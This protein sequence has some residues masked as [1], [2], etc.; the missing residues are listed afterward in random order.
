MLALGLAALLVL[1]ALAE[2]HVYARTAAVPVRVRVA[3]SPA[4]LPHGGA[5]ELTLRVERAG[6]LPVPWLTA[7]ITLPPDLECAAAQGRS[8]IAHLALP[9]RGALVRHYPVR[10]RHRGLYRVEGVRV[11][12][13][14][15]LGL[16]VRHV[17]LAARAEMLVHPRLVAADMVASTRT[18]LGEVEHTALLEDP[19]AY[20]GV[21]PYLPGDPLRRVHWPQ[22]ARTG[23]LMAREYATAAAAQVHLALNLATRVPH[24]AGTD[25]A[26]V[27]QVIEAAASLAAACCRAAVPVGL[28]VNGVAF[29]ATPITRLPPG[30]SPR[31]LTRLLDVLARLAPQPSA[32]AAALLDALWSVPRDAN[33]VLVTGP[34]P[35]AWRQGLPPLARTRDVTA[36]VL[37]RPGEPVPVLP[38]VR[39]LRLVRAEE[40]EEAP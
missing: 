2:R 21:R 20:R 8:L 23:Q 11:E 40:G 19:T 1:L 13:T 34:M 29:E 9:L 3:L 4:R 24:W 16:V 6:I 27:E 12:Y 39:L 36:V 33:L 18:L 26:R 7:Y 14:D 28:V 38:G 32:S 35:E 37:A 31:H 15:P 25:V 17:D 30:A 10:P 22:T 5:G